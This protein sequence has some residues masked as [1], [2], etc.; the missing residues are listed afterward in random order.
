M[1]T[2]QGF[3]EKN[4]RYVIY[5]IVNQL[6]VFWEI[7]DS[8]SAARQR[9]QELAQLPHETDEFFVAHPTIG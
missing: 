2:I 1:I 3:W 7:A 8:E 6:A 5:K 4:M 9:L